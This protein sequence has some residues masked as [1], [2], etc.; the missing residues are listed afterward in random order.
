M[1]TATIRQALRDEQINIYMMTEG[2][3]TYPKYAQIFLCKRRPITNT[4]KGSYL[5]LD[6][7]KSSST[8]QLSGLGKEILAGVPNSRSNYV[9]QIDSQLEIKIS[10]ELFADLNVD[11]F[12]V[13]TAEAPV[14]YFEGLVTGFLII[15]RVFKIDTYIDPKYLEKGRK[16]RNAVFGLFDSADRTIEI[17]VKNMEPALAEGEFLLLKRD[18]IQKLKG[19]DALIKMID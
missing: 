2:I 10:P 15:F 12:P 6:S 1:E 4:Q 17:E 11:Y 8:F 19:Y 14:Q 13:W 16:G 7:K 5:L 3:A 9:A 18:I